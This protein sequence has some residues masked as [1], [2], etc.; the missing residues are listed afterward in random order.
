MDAVLL[1]HSPDHVEPQPVGTVYCVGLNY[2][3]HAA[4]MKSTRPDEPMIFIKPASSLVTENQPVTYPALTQD[5]HHEVELVVC[6]NRGGRHLSLSEAESAV[7]AYGLGLDLTLRDRQAEAKAKGRPWSVSK[8]FAQS[9][10]VSELQIAPE[11]KLPPELD[12]SLSLNGETRQQGNTRDMLFSVSELIVYLSSV[13]EL[14]RGDLIYTGTPAG[15]GPLQR[16]DTAVAFLGSERLL[17]CEV[18]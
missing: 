4:E 11:G 14:R 5:L 15:V 12:F 8:G 13:F 16:G 18:V 9:A 7:L 1:R 10:P 3:D 6:L 2:A 17:S